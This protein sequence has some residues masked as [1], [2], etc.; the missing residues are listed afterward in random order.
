M[1]IK[2]LIA[3]AALALATQPAQAVTDV[4]ATFLDAGSVGSGSPIVTLNVPSG[5][6]AIFAKLGLD[7]DDSTK[8]VTVVCKLQAGLDFDQDH[9]RLAPSGAQNL[10]NA[11]IPFQVVH[12]FR[13]GTN[14]PI[15]LSCTFKASQSVLLSFRFAKITAIRIDGI[16]CNRVSPANCP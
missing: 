4:F 1:P 13:P 16:L 3:V 5:K 8:V 12:S 11:A 10:D 9:I 2:H 6:Y 7:Q 14:N 15:T